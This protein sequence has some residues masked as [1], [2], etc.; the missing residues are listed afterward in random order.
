MKRLLLL[1]A[2]VVMMCNVVMSQQSLRLSFMGQ[3]GDGYYQRMDYIEIQNVT[4]DWFEVLYYPDTIL[5]ISP[6]VN[7]NE[8]ENNENICVTP[9]VFHGETNVNIP[10]IWSS[11]VASVFITQFMLS[12]ISAIS[13]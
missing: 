9:S 1:L 2:S 5:V 6:S 7:V 13:Y 12:L 4:R 3:I 8:N 10:S 11:P